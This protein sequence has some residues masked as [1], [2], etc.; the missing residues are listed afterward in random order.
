MGFIHHG[1]AA[2]KGYGDRCLHRSVITIDIE[3]VA[4]AVLRKGLYGTDDELL[5]D[6]SLAF[7]YPINLAHRY[8]HRQGQFSETPVFYGI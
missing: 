8:S 6:F 7:P 2:L 5:I 3:K 4:E 1:T